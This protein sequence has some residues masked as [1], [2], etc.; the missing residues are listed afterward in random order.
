LRRE[1]ARQQPQVQVDGAT[2]QAWFSPNTKQHSKPKQDPP[3]PVDLADVDALIAAAKHG[4][5]FLLFQPGSPSVLDPISAAQNAGDKLFVRGAVTDPHAVDQFNVE[6]HHRPGS[7]PDIVPAAAVQDAFGD[8]EKELLKTPGGHAIIHDK[9][10]VIDPF[11][12][13]CVVVTGSHNLGYTASYKNDENMLIV[14]GNRELAQAYAAHVID[15]YDHYRWRYRLQTEKQHAWS[16]LATDDSWQ[17]VYFT[18][19]RAVELG[20]WQT[21]APVAA[22]R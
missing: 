13:D 2:V 9:V 11:D 6:L 16:S 12:D 15:L 21:G 19:A 3:E 1:D 14:R 17:D 18:A 22:G 4:I 20:F 7:A 5:L 10:I 8:W